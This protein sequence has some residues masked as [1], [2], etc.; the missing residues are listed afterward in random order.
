MTDGQFLWGDFMAKAAENKIIKRNKILESAYNLFMNKSVTATAI[1]DV[2]K[3]A[4]VAKGTFY[5]YFKD[6][7]D[8]LEQIVIYKSAGV[9]RE[10][11]EAIEKNDLTRMTLTDKVLF[12]A[13]YVSDYLHK[14]R[15]LTALLNKN[16]SSCLRYAMTGT[17]NEYSDILERFTNAL[18]AE[19]YEKREAE[20][21]IYLLVDMV[22][23][24]CCDAVLG[25]AP[26]SFEEIYP[27]LRQTIARITEARN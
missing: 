7:Y 20:M 27:Y 15:D 18:V 19:G 23:S 4:G 17:E 10:S 21:T 9:I 16:L 5:L 11:I 14:N 1:D 26:F 6:K 12:I 25:T 3:M 22:G 2:V 8:L 24:A 13:D